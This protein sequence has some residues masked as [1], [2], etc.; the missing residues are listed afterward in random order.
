[1]ASPEYYEVQA[2]L[3]VRK[4]SGRKEEFLVKW[5]NSR[6]LTWEPSG[7][8]GSG[9]ND[10]KEVWYQLNDGYKHQHA[11]TL[12]QKKERFRGRKLTESVA[13]PA[14]SGDDYTSHSE[15]SDDDDLKEEPLNG[16]AG[17]YQTGK[18]NEDEK[19]KGYLASPSDTTM[20]GTNKAPAAPRPIPVARFRGGLFGMVDDLKQNAVLRV[21]NTAGVRYLPETKLNKLFIEYLYGTDVESSVMSDLQYEQAVVDLMWSMAANLQGLDEAT[22]SDLKECLLRLA[23]QLRLQPATTSKM[24]QDWFNRHHH[25]H[26]TGSPSYNLMNVST[27]RAICS[28]MSTLKDEGATKMEDFSETGSVADVDVDALLKGS[29]DVEMEEPIETVEDPIV[30]EFT[31]AQNEMFGETEDTD[32]G[33]ICTL[34]HLVYAAKNPSKLSEVTVEVGSGLEWPR[35]VDQMPGLIAKYSATL[36][37]LY[38]SICK[39]YGV[40]C[41]EFAIQSN[42]KN[43]RTMEDFAAYSLAS[44][45]SL[46]ATY[47][48]AK[49]DEIEDIMAKNAN[50]EMQVVAAIRQKYDEG[51]GYKPGM[52]YPPSSPEYGIME[53]I[54]EELAVYNPDLLRSIEHTVFTQ[55]R[56]RELYVYL[57]ICDKYGVTID[58]D[59]LAAVVETYREKQNT[60]R[61][62]QVFNVVKEIYKTYNRG[63]VKDIHRLVNKFSKST[64]S[65]LELIQAVC[66][67]FRVPLHVKVDIISRMLDPGAL[68]LT[69]HS[70]F[71]EA[72][73][74]SDLSMHVW[75]LIQMEMSSNMDSHLVSQPPMRLSGEDASMLTMDRL[76]GEEQW[77][78]VEMLI[79]GRG[80]MISNE[81]IMRDLLDQKVHELGINNYPSQLRYRITQQEPESVQWDSF[82]VAETPR[83]SCTLSMNSVSPPEPSAAGYRPQRLWLSMQDL[84]QWIHH[85]RQQYQ[86]AADELAQSVLQ[87]GGPEDGPV[88]QPPLT[89]KREQ[90][91]QPL[92]SCNVAL[93]SPKLT[94]FAGDYRTLII[95]E[96]PECS[97]NRQ[98]NHVW[99]LPKGSR[100]SDIVDKLRAACAA[101]PRW[102]RHGGAVII[103]YDKVHF[104][105]GLRRRAMYREGIK[106][107]SRL[108]GDEAGSVRIPRYMLSLPLG[109]LQ[110]QLQELV[111]DYDDH[112]SQDDYGESDPEVPTELI[113]P[114]RLSRQQM[115]D[116]FIQGALCLNCDDITH[117]PADCGIRRK[118]CW[119]CHGAH[120]GHTC[121]TRC[122]FCQC[123]HSAFVLLECVKRGGRR[124]Q[125]WA[126]NRHYQEQFQLNRTYLDVE[127]AIASAETAGKQWSDEI[128]EMVRILYNAGQWLPNSWK[129]HFEKALADASAVKS[130]EGG[131]QDQ[132]SAADNEA[133]VATG[134]IKP[135]LPSTPPPI[136]PDQKYKWIERI[137]LDELLGAGM[138]GRDAVRAI[139]GSR[140][141]NHKEMESATQSRIY[142]RGM[143]MKDGGGAEEMPDL[144]HFDTEA[145]IHVLVKCDQPPQARA[146]RSML[147]RIIRGLESERQRGH[148]SQWLLHAQL[149]GGGIQGL[150]ITLG[151]NRDKEVNALQHWLHAQGIEAKT[152]SNLTRILIPSTRKI[153]ASVAIKEREQ[154]GEFD[155]KMEERKRIIN[156]PAV[157]HSV[158]SSLFQLF[159]LW[160]A[161]P[162]AVSGV[163]WFEPW[164]LEPIG[165][166]GRIRATAPEGQPIE[167]DRFWMDVGQRCRLSRKG[168]EE[169][170]SLLEA[171]EELP[172]KVDKDMCVEILRT[173]VGSV[174]CA[175][176]DHRLLLYLRYPWAMVHTVGDDELT[177]LNLFPRNVSV[178]LI[179]KEIRET[180]R[181]G[182]NTGDVTAL[183]SSV[184]QQ[185][186]KSG[187]R[188][189]D[190]LLERLSPDRVPEMEPPYIGFA[191][192]WLLPDDVLLH[193]AAAAAAAGHAGGPAGGEVRA[194]YGDE[195]EPPQRVPIAAPVA[196]P[197]PSPTEPRPTTIKGEMGQDAVIVDDASDHAPQNQR[198]E[199][200]AMSVAQLREKLRAQGLPVTG[201]KTD[202]VDRLLKKPLGASQKTAQG[203]ALY[204][205]RVELPAQ[206]M[207]WHELRNN[208]CGDRNAH[209]EHVHSQCPGTK[210][211]LAGNQSAALQGSARLHVLVTTNGLEADYKR[212]KDLVV[213]L[214]KAVAEH[215]AEVM[216]GDLSPTQLESVLA[217]IKIVELTTS[218]PAA[219]PAKT[220]GAGG[221]SEGSG[222]AS[223]G[224]AGAGTSSAFNRL[225][226]ALQA[227][228][229]KGSQAP[230]GAAAAPNAGTPTGRQ[231]ASYEDL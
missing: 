156:S 8:I 39:K 109:P 59:R 16:A 193:T 188:P 114:L 212:A 30:A 132:A 23:R 163:Y 32:E 3:D 74:K 203:P 209:F 48:P 205:C 147:I 99:F 17:D 81:V 115:R 108:L 101:W 26:A 137:F 126:K 175:A 225:F 134:S 172:D 49:L 68:D 222:G 202:L 229:A 150:E 72:V 159:A 84:L 218:V 83:L 36:K 138:L 152:D 211:S 28:W 170:A 207:G 142:F 208:L 215:G 34:I 166:I 201:R 146:V 185:S 139:V 25:V 195:G 75:G 223:Q 192:E 191:V 194:Q 143:G 141:Q 173:F 78:T 69:W 44:A 10:V 2:L 103:D 187:D 162:P 189:G 29:D 151:D 125:E 7:N 199:Y 33:D 35:V 64:S 165:L 94:V 66:N 204:K 40:D 155:D 54:R 9:L 12:R 77:T 200:M 182:T 184:K 231:A 90:P 145:R 63:K 82:W 89:A 164:Q 100:R 93:V 228:A 27:L 120:Q 53:L 62:A 160:P 167:D 1:M 92:L 179:N 15:S 171:M 153:E 121:T 88:V 22:L 221:D 14:A 60:Q 37:A 38:E 45:R 73:E 123:N 118:V 178:H 87:K 168:A 6:E 149:P 11:Q 13:S 58:E 135:V 177:A 217:E 128:V 219:V 24:L 174:Q 181:L 43:Y 136:L 154:P 104:I 42:I 206:L 70:K 113:R 224:A 52:Y 111:S 148:G 56:S 51:R 133:S 55:Y 124:A 112:E 65:E 61:Q 214:A 19:M 220:S 85:I 158:Y 46:Y 183:K 216:L 157:R 213:D 80:G 122:R 226:G 20:G 119:N 91:T 86:V 21:A 198:E 230:G 144:R 186:V 41:A 180:G 169:V 117:K 106:Q 76:S 102:L 47:N 196:V 129:E 140:G 71:Q 57:A 161:Q 67:K 210:L 96:Y 227:A 116:A 176:R 190:H 5:K 79:R 130:E 31:K 50:Q 98:Q 127:Q 107:I 131:G 105:G 97:L 95:D 4:I 18:L 197:S 110:P